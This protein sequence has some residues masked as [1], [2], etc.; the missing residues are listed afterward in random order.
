MN[1][2][3]TGVSRWRLGHWVAAMGAALLLTLSPLTY[4]QWQQ[5]TLMRDTQVNRSTP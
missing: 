4:I 5:F 3:Q 1:T 2:P